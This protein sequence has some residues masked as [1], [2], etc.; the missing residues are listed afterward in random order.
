MHPTDSRLEVKL[1]RGMI[2]SPQAKVGVNMKNVLMLMLV[3][4]ALA[5]LANASERE[6]D[7]T[8][9]L[10][11]RGV[12]KNPCRCETHI[13]GPKFKI[14]NNTIQLDEVNFLTRLDGDTALLDIDNVNSSVRLAR[15]DSKNAA[16]VNEL[17]SY[18]EG[19][20]DPSKSDIDPNILVSL[21]PVH[22][23]V[24]KYK[25]EKHFE[26]FLHT[27]AGTIPAPRLVTTPTALIEI[28]DLDG[29]I[30]CYAENMPEIADGLSL[31]KC[32]AK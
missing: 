14:G 8:F 21:D 13:A 15:L 31:G 11:I 18:A 7:V 24:L 6:A 9:T 2:E 16:R 19:A 12:L 20:P 25:V 30:L 28:T 26:A 1:K 5:P 27:D 4:S 23:K 10:P 29:K 17:V 3:A 32:N 22:V